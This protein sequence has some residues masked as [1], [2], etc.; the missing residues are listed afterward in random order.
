V[1]KRP[2]KAIGDDDLMRAGL[3]LRV[4]VLSRPIEID[5]IA[6]PL[7][8]RH[9]KTFPSQMR[10]K[11][12]HQLGF[13][14]AVADNSKTLHKNPFE[15]ERGLPSARRCFI[16]MLSRRYRPGRTETHL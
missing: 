15:R 2:A 6:D 11:S 1:Q 12:L 9:H 7:Q 5:V 16:H 14:P 8:R 13:A 3:A 10:D 4:G